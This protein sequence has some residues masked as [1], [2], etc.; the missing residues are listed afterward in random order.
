M[1]ANLYHGATVLLG[2]LAAW[3]LRRRLRQ[4]G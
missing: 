4:G 1:S 2:P 3:Y